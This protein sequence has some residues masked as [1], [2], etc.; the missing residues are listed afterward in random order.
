MAIADTIP[1]NW[2]TGSEAK[3]VASGIFYDMMISTAMRSNIVIKDNQD[4]EELL[5][6]ISKER[7][8]SVTEVLQDIQNVALTVGA[9]KLFRQKYFDISERFPKDDFGNPSY[10]P[11]FLAKILGIDEMVAENILNGVL[12]EYSVYLSDENTEN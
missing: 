8:V 3:E 4:L 11:D 6:V 2:Y 7:N 5:D 9:V 12:K 1:D 10:P